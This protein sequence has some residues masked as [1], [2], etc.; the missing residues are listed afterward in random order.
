[1]P[2]V[3]FL[4]VITNICIVGIVIF[5]QQEFQE[6]PFGESDIPTQRL[7]EPG[8][9]IDVYYVGKDLCI[10]DSSGMTTY[11]GTQG[12]LANGD[13]GALFYMAFMQSYSGYNSGRGEFKYVETGSFQG[14]SAHIVAEVIRTTS[15]S[16]IIYSHDL[17]DEPLPVGNSDDAE[18]LWQQDTNANNNRLGA[19][20]SNVLRNGLQH[21]IIPI[22][23]IYACYFL[24]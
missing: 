7:A 1:M 3:F 14:L 2:L 11:N 20:Y 17:F 6:S 13:C 4:R 10:L 9:N 21:I 8:G 16:G 15:L 19:F 5:G 12:M 24:V 23:G 18:S 22:P